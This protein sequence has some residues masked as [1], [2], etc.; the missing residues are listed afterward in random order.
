MYQ[1]THGGD[2][3]AY[4][5]RKVLDFSAN[6]NP[7]GLP[8]GVKKAIVEAVDSCDIYPDPLCQKLRAAIAKAED[9]AT[10]HIF[11]GA[12]AADI[13]FRLTLALKPKKALLAVPSFSEYQEALK[14]INCEIEY[15]YMLESEN[16][17]LTERFLQRLNDDVD[18]IFLCNP[19]NPTGHLIDSKLLQQIMQKCQRHHITLVIDECFIDFLPDAQERT[20]KHAISQ[21]QN[22][23]VLKAYTKLLAM[24]GVRLGYC[25]CGNHHIL[26]LL[27]KSGQPW[28][29]S[30]LAQQAGIAAS[31]EKDYFS[32]SLPI[33][34]TE[35]QR[36][37]QALLD[38]GCQVFDSKANFIFFKNSD[39][40]DLK[41]ALLK[42]NIL[43]R[44]C[45]NYE[46]LSQG[47]YRISI[48]TPSENDVLI[49]CLKKQ[50]K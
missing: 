2:I 25:F 34:G 19:N 48:K 37:Q 50:F 40:F 47:Y 44:S 16:F 10:E 4:E 20:V 6:I 39:A 41:E 49:D 32:N 3:Y 43:I 21:Y 7:F 29:V 31:A 12:G 5:N 26:E 22:L 17:S 42:D 14:S 30:S 33:I 11:C 45:E 9:A 8:H 13:L 18:I 46:G 28:N 23:I 35:R 38:V 27:Y 15:Y 36:L 1:Y 24:A